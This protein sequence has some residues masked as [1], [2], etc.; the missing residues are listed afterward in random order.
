MTAGRLLVDT[1]VLIA[2]SAELSGARLVT[3]NRKHFPML[4]DVLVP[5]AKTS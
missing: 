2:A 4:P 1:D 3:L 5:Y